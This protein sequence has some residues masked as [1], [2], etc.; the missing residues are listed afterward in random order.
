MFKKLPNS[1]R[2]FI[3]TEKARI[4]SQF[5]DYKKQE[6]QIVE[7]YKKVRNQ[8]LAEVV[9]EIKPK[10][11]VKKAEPKKAQKKQNKKQKGKKK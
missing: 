6:E 2:K 5:L 1:T 10:K 11:E 7:L 4:R 3:R 8:P 9:G